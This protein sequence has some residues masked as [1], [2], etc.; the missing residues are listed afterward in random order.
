MIE[1]KEIT[2]FQHVGK[3]Q[4]DKFLISELLIP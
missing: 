3:I 1:F 4:A 2:L